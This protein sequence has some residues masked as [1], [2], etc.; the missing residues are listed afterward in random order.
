[1]FSL[2]QYVLRESLKQLKIERGSLLRP[3]LIFFLTQPM[4][5]DR[6]NREAILF[7]RSHS[8]SDHHSPHEIPDVPVRDKPHS[9]ISLTFPSSY[10]LSCLYIAL[11]PLTMATS[12]IMYFDHPHENNFFV[13]P[14]QPLISNDINSLGPTSEN[15]CVFLCC[16]PVCS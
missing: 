9:F 5:V 4:T 16:V 7:R 2:I 13:H 15:V 3:S 14:Q 1:M 6:D 10:S 12:Q 8:H 11:D